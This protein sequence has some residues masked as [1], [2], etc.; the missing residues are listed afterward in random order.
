MFN[1]ARQPK[2]AM[3]L[4]KPTLPDKLH[5]TS[6]LGRSHLHAAGPVPR[7]QG[8]T[9]RREYGQTAGALP[10]DRRRG[11]APDISTAGADLR[12]S[13]WLALLCRRSL[14]GGWQ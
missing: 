11:L 10:R 14:R 8:L 5:V 9:C 7:G 2:H 4:V 3:D 12:S 1:P 13:A 6:E